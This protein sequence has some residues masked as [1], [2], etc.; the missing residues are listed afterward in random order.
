MRFRPL[1]VHL[2]WGASSTF[3]VQANRVF[4]SMIGLDSMHD[5]WLDPCTVFGFRESTANAFLPSVEQDGYCHHPD[6]LSSRR[7]GF[8]KPWSF[9]KG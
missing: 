3:T 4:I 6:D 9:G 5:P 1:G 7:T 8:A 2:G